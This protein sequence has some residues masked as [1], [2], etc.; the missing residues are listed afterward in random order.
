MSEH[1]L[2]RGQQRKLP[3]WMSM[4]KSYTV[5]EEKVC[6]SSVILS[7]GKFNVYLTVN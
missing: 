1:T 3:E 6:S 7:D 5:K 4:Q 2:E